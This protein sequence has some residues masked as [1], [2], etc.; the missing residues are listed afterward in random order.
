[1]TD[2]SLKLM[3]CVCLCVCVCLSSLSSLATSGNSCSFKI[4]LLIFILHIDYFLIF[5]GFYTFVFFSLCNLRR[6]LKL[7]FH[8]ANVMLQ[9]HFCLFLPSKYFKIFTLLYCKFWN[10]SFTY[11]YCF[12]C[13]YLRSQ[14]FFFILKIQNY[15]LKFFFLSYYK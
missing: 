10:I 13:L 2:L 11:L 15:C 3:E 8:I 4:V 14:A 5:D 9:W 7:A 6:N 1:M 12:L